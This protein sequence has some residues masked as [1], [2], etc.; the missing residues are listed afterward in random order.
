MTLCLCISTTGL[1]IAGA[2]GQRNASLQP[3]QFVIGRYTFFDFG[4]PD[5]FYEFFLVRQ[6]RAGLSIEKLTLSPPGDPCGSPATCET[7]TASLNQSIA[8]LLGRDPCSIPEKDL[9]REQK[10]C[11]NCLTF[12]GARVS[13]QVQCGARTR[14]ILS[15]ILDKD[16]FGRAPHTPENTSWT[17]ALLE[18]LDDAI[19]DPGVMEKKMI[20]LPAEGAPRTGAQEREVEREL[21]A[22]KYDGLFKEVPDTPSVLYATTKM[23][24]AVPSIQLLSS[25]P[26]R[27]DILV[28][29]LYP[30][31]A[32]AAHVEGKV[33]F[34]VDVDDRGNA[35]N[36]TIVS[37]HALL[38]QA[39]EAAVK[40]WRFPKEAT[41]QQVEAVVEFKQ[42]CPNL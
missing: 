4:P 5:H 20:E 32:K 30:P 13:M 3:D 25:I 18:K 37:G 23:T 35:T 42:N 24:P 21:A 33:D 40:K 7:A 39:V 9:K 2:A 11:K 10:R 15:S 22:G 12:S 34:K 28:A 26:S 29:P 1:S 19:G 16:M 14:T 6:T 8:E 36:F 38:R 41:G 27:P 31:L 17:M